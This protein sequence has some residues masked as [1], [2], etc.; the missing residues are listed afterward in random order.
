MKI[1]SKK[2]EIQ[3][4]LNEIREGKIVSFIPTMGSL[5]EGHISLLENA[6][7]NSDIVICSIFVNPTQFNNHLDFQKY[8][9]QEN[10]DIDILTEN[11][12]DILYLPDES[13]LY[14]QNEKAK[15]F[16]FDGL[17]MF[18]EGVG[19]KGHFNGVATI[20]EKLFKI[21]TP[22]KAFFGEKDLQ[23]LQIIRHITKKLQFSIEII[24]VATKRE[25]SGLAISSRNKLL[26]PQDLQKAAIIY[27]TLKFVKNNSS[28]FTID[29]LKKLSIEKFALQKDMTLE[30]LEI[31]SLEKL[32]PISEILDK[33]ENA[34]C[35]AASIDS[36][37][38]I[39]NIIF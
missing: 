6:K 25:K 5:H 24:G 27:Q 20:V 18:M 38:L 16:D 12:C 17:D 39:D 26:L 36:V 31:V 37:R 22:E 35:I 34:A 9:R 29:E 13:D 7:Q 21:L 19:R 3:L 8:P 4:Y 33:N 11:K 15:R 14:E 28:N 2:S 1:F 23:Q 30:Y 10:V 32:Q